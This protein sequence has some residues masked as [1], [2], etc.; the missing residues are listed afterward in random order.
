MNQPPPDH[1]SEANPFAASHVQDLKPPKQG[2]TLAAIIVAMALASLAYRYLAQA[3]L[4]QTTLLFICVPA[5][6]AFWVSLAAPAK[7]PTGMT[8][9]AITLFLLIAGMFL[10][11]GVICIVIASPIFFLVGALVAMPF[12]YIHRRGRA[13]ERRREIEREQEREQDRKINRDRSKLL[14][15]L[16][17]TPWI[18]ILLFG[19]G[20]ERE[21][22]AS[23]T[24]HINATPADIAHSLEKGP[25]FQRPPPAVLSIGFPRPQLE[26]NDGSAA[27]NTVAFHFAGGEGKPGTSQWE[28]T[29]SEN[30]FQ[31]WTCREDRSHLAHWMTWRSATVQWAAAGAGT[32][33]TWS[34]AWRRDLDPGWYFAPIEWAGAHLA[35]DHVMTVWATPE[36]LR[37][38]AA[39]PT[40]VRSYIT[41]IALLLVG[42]AMTRLSRRRRLGA[43]IAWIAGVPALWL[44][45]VVA[46]AQGWWR[47]EASGGCIAGIPLDVV[48]A[49]AVL[50]A[51]VPALVM[52]WHPALVIIIA[53][54]LD[55]IIMPL[56]QPLVILEANWLLGEGFAVILILVPAVLLARWSAARTKPAARAALV[57]VAFLTWL[58][59]VGSAAITWEG[60]ELGGPTVRIIAG[61]LA[62]SGIA[63]GNAAIH[64]FAQRGG[65]TPLPFDPPRRLVRSGIY[66]YIGNPMQVAGVLL[67]LAASIAYSSWTMALAALIIIAY[68]CGFAAW[69]ERGDLTRRYGE[70]YSTWRQQVRDW[71]PRWRPA[72]IIAAADPAEE[73][74][75]SDQARLWVG[76]TCGICSGLA[77]WLLAQNPRGII[78]IPAE[79]HPQ[80][81]LRIRYECGA[82]QVTGVAALAAAL[83]HLHLGWAV[84][85]MLLRLP[86]IAAF[87]QIFADAIGAGPR[88]L[89]QRR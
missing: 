50:W 62:I 64:D 37:P 34:V 48:L 39:D 24:R 75:H 47:F 9:R 53:V 14:P 3:H 21:Q 23:V 76:S 61:W 86:G 57:G 79:T 65:G 59:A 60:A 7:S 30:G 88:A 83:E 18:G 80:P 26:T 42:V 5:F 84:I 16:W 8:M 28:V 31:E 17:L 19:F 70:Q 85:G 82:H 36:A 52:R 11:E 20:G 13:E 38:A 51:V 69:S 35:L 87:A 68:A 32:D 22:Q 40:W 55:L 44:L 49:W 41:L 33:V 2:W 1:D 46:L 29:R 89:G 45:N 10:G 67:G 74:D 78:I 58:V 71:W 43:M 66:A 6:I 4:E 56:L 15:L 81:L 63:L 72:A 25:D 27:G 73:T 77:R 12:E 54:I